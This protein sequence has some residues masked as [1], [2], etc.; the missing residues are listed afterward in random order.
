MKLRNPS[1]YISKWS[2]WS[3]ARTRCTDVLC[4]RSE[5]RRQKKKRKNNQ[6][7]ITN[8]RTQSPPQLRSFNT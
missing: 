3:T 6:T 5:R 2:S 8:L 7:I 1:D 4:S